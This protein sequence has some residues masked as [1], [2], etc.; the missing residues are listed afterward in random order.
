M[1]ITGLQPADRAR[2]T[3][4]WGAYLAFYKTTLPEDVY[5][6]T[7]ARLLD[8]SGAVRGVAARSDE[9]EKIIGIT[10]FLFHETAWNGS[11]VCYLQDLFVDPASRGQGCGRALIEAV[12]AQARERN[13]CGMYWLTQDFNATARRLYDAVATNDGFVRYDYSLD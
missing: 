11:A 12:A 3:E 4:L 1:R 9:N 13:C 6:T 7:W 8:G 2:W 5:D 10:H